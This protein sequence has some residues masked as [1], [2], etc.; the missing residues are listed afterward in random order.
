MCYGVCPS[1]DKVLVVVKFQL[2]SQ[3]KERYL[4][5]ILKHFFVLIQTQTKIIFSWRSFFFFYQ[6]ESR[7]RSLLMFCVTGVVET[8]F[9]IQIQPQHVC[10][11]HLLASCCQLWVWLCTMQVCFVGTHTHPPP[12]KEVLSGGSVG[13]VPQVEPVCD[14]IL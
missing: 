2:C 13:K 14:F 10:A 9:A 6:L 5:L 7:N 11:V 4:S 12:G 1:T 8:E 3:M